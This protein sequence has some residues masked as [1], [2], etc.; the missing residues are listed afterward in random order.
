MEER[1]ELHEWLNAKPSRSFCKT[2][3][4]SGAHLSRGNDETLCGRLMFSDK[5]AQYIS[6]ADASAVNIC[7]SCWKIMQKEM[8]EIMAKNTKNDETVETVDLADALEGV[9]DAVDPLAAAVEQA[10]ANIDRAVSLAEAENTEGLAELAKEHETLVSGMPNRGNI[11]AAEGEPKMTWAAFKKASRDDFRKASQA[12][13]KPEAKAKETAKEAKA[14]ELELKRQAEAEAAD[15]TK[16]EG[17]RERVEET[18]RL[19]TEGVRLHVKTAQTARQA[20]ETFL[21][22]QRLI[23]TS[24]G[25]PDLK[26]VEPKSLKARKDVYETAREELS[27]EGDPEHAKALVEKFRI[28]VKNQTSDVL[29]GM[30]RA[31]D[32]SPEE[33]AHYAKIAE[34]R[35]EL[36]E[37]PVSERVFEFYSIP[38]MSK[39]ELMAQREAEK[40]AKLKELEAAKAE[41]DSEA[42]EELEELKTETVAQ[43]VAHKFQTGDKAIRDALKDAKELGEDDKAA[44]KAK[45]MEL[46][47][48][49][50]EL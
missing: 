38:R 18:S 5:G 45:I 17:V 16:V 41:G 24:D 4:K 43:K 26:C 25:L 12:Q 8:G 21:A 48:L 13:P 46:V 9:T 30:V 6:S 32:D 28:A 42:A 34:L 14:A 31:L 40:R 1:N 20:A 29:V 19:I 37:L 49:A 35:P 3:T 7:G 36:A 39:R 23:L 50:N 44:L 47:A 15:Y 33:A 2:S 27:K 10:Q 22:G 11:P